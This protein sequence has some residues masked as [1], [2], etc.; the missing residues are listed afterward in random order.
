ME[1]N[2]P[3]EKLGF[4][5]LSGVQGGGTR[6]RLIPSPLSAGVNQDPRFFPPEIH[7]RFNW[8]LRELNR[9]SQRVGG[10]GAENSALLQTKILLPLAGIMR[11]KFFQPLQTDLKV[12]SWYLP[13]SFKCI[14]KN[15]KQSMQHTGGTS[16]FLISY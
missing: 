6:Q 5:L 10:V 7:F 13:H 4:Y 9:K 11:T 2:F 16:E 3:R 8:N 1:I 14:N 12:S 15:H